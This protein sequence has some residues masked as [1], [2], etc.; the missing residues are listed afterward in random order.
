MSKLWYAVF[1]ARGTHRINVYAKSADDALRIAG[2]ANGQ[3]A[4]LPVVHQPG[5]F[6]YGCR[7]ECAGKKRGL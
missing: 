3:A 5:C 2:V 7:G 1:D 6:G 4:L